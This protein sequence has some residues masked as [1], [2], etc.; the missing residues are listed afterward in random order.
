MAE[1]PISKADATTMILR[2]QAD[3]NSGKIKGGKVSSDS[4]MSILNQKGCSAL[5]YYFAKNDAGENTLILV[6]EDATGTILSDG[7]MLDTL[8]PCP[9]YCPSNPLG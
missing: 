3:P 9:P 6:G 5:R 8:P 2:Y 4:V 7:L 1:S